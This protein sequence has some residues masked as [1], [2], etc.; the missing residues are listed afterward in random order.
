LGKNNNKTA[1]IPLGYREGG[2]GAGPGPRLNKI[3]SIWS[4]IGPIWSK[5]GPI[6]SKID[7]IWANIV[8]Y[9]SQK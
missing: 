2:Q 3:G 1:G 5:I 9:W 4:K 6:W 8:G 7:P